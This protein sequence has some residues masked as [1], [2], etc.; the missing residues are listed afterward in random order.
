M[1]RRRLAQFSEPNGLCLLPPEVAEQVGYD[2]VVADTVNHALRG[3]RLRDGHVRRLAGNGKQWM[4]GDPLPD[5][6]FADTPMSSPWDVAWLPAWSEVA[7]A[8]AGNHQLWSFDP[9]TGRLTVRGGTTQEGLVDG[10]PDEALLA[11]PSGLAASSGGGT[12]WFVDAETSS[13]RRVT[14]GVVHTEIGSGLFDFGH[15]DG[16]ATEALMQHPL[17]CC[18]LADG[19]VAVADTYN[20]AIRRFDPVTREMSTLVTELSEPSGLAVAGSELV[21]VESSAHRVTRVRLPEEVLVVKG[22][23]MQSQRPP[24][25][26]GRDRRRWRSPSRRHPGRSWTTATGHRST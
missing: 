3:V 26:C 23:G 21:V 16:P 9:L 17:A 13:L 10:K 20:G 25:P 19:S 2:V 1:A 5:K 7:V 18:T 11:Q 4:Q 24:R 15:V 6:A 12:L 8:M 22:K 14:N